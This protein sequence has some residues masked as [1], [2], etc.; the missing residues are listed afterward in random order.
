[1]RL[2][3]YHHNFIAPSVFKRTIDVLDY[4]T[5]TI[6]KKVQKKLDMFFSQSVVS[7]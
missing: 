2:N 7:P 3:L 1:M 5:S 6:I 4:K